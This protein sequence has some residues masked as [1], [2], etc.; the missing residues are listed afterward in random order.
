VKIEL[1][2]I[3]KT[4]EVSKV[5]MIDSETMEIFHLDR[6]K[7]G[8]FRLTYSKSLIPEIKELMSLIMGK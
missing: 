8:K 3:E 6:L 4:L 5:T 2:G 1:Q 7:D